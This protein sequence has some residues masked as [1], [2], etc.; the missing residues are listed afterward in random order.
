MILALMLYATALTFLLALAAASLET[1]VRQQGWPVRG[2]WIGAGLGSIALSVLAVLLPERDPVAAAR[3]VS[4]PVADAAAGLAWL[5]TQ[6]ASAP[7]FRLEPWLLALWGI[8]SAA[9]VVVIGISRS[10]VRRRSREWVLQDVDG[11]AVWVSGDTGPAVVGVL[12]SR[13][14]IPDWVLERGPGD[15]SLVLAHEEEHIRARDPQLLFATLLLLAALP[16]NLPLWWLW[17]RLRQAVELDCDHRVLARGLDPRAYS[18]LLVN[19]AQWG[20]P[21]RLVVTALSESPSFLERRLSLMLVSR[22]LRWRIRALLSTLSASLLVT[23]ACSMGRPAGAST[24]RVTVWIAPP[25]TYHLQAPESAAI[26]QP[27]LGAALRTALARSGEPSVLNVRAIKGV[28]GYDFV[29]MV[30][31]ACEAGVTRIDAVGDIPASTRDVSA[32]PAEMREVRNIEQECTRI[33]T[34]PVTRDTLPNPARR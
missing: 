18:H 21:R 22:P 6:P 16:W 5:G 10:R 15:R 24:E 32:A 9:I 11:R 12:R 17:R 4:A 25:G 13:I 29:M 27:Q 26:P 3:F 34:G 23:T 30:H 8:A 31:A 19:V 33:R 2:L 14:V 7:P 20:N 1:T 28:V